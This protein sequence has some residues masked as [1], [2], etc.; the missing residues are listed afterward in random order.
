MIR[1]KN[2]EPCDTIETI[3]EWFYKCPPKGKDNHWKDGRSAKETAKHWL[4]AIPQAFREILKDKNLIYEQCSP[5]YVSKFDGYKGEGRNHDLL[6]IAKDNNQNPLVI[7]IES[8][9]DEPFGDTVKKKTEAALD[10]KKKNQNSRAKERIE[11]LWLCL[12]GETIDEN[13]TIKYQLMTAVA[14]TICEAKKQGAKT[15]YFLVQTFVEKENQKHLDNK[16]D[17]DDF[18]HKLSKGNFSNLEN[19]QIVGPFTVVK[20]TEKLP[21]D[22][23]LFIGKFEIQI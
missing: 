15:A 12:F 10:A 19:N 23:E 21:D 20:P 7:S 1:C 4:H 17:L 11:E 5:E 14:G 16:K 2:L 6:I 18:I 3:Y 13:A 8:K 9:A 22:I